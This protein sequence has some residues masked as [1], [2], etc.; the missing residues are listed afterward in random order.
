MTK[1]VHAM[2]IQS[3]RGRVKAPREACIE[4]PFRA[5]NQNHLKVGLDGFPPIKGIGIDRSDIE[6][7]L[8]TQIRSV[9]KRGE[10]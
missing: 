2:L 3:E 5:S 4:E 8:G 1:R 6:P 7:N 9:P 10:L